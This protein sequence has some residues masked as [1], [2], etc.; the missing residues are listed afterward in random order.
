M[1]T[2]PPVSTASSLYDRK[3]ATESLAKFDCI[4]QGAVDKPV[5]NVLSC[6]MHPATSSVCKLLPQ[7]P[8][9]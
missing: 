7:V 6:S 8:V 3:V 4:R 2:Q 9:G 1:I 5:I